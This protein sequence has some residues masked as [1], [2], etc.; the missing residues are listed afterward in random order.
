VPQL[1]AH[2]ELLEKTAWIRALLH[3]LSAGVLRK[4]NC[5]AQVEGEKPRW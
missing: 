3:S 1:Y 4:V 5:H 2:W